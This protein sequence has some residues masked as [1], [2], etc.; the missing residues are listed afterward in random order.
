MATEQKSMPFGTT[1]TTDDTIRVTALA[2]AGG[3]N[4][5]HTFTIPFEEPPEVL[6]GINEGAT[7]AGIAVEVTATT[8]T[9]HKDGAGPA[10]NTHT[11]LRGK[12]KSTSDK[13]P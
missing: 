10:E 3:G 12:L 5:V 8:C 13:L 2:L 7:P 1:N 6:S 4:D 9:I 11:L